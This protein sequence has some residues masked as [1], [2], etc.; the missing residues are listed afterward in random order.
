[1][2]TADSLVASHHACA[3]VAARTS[4]IQPELLSRDD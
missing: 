2:F 1:L 4:M 3:T